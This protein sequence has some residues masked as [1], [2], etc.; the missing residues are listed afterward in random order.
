MCHEIELNDKYLWIGSIT[1]DELKIC[2]KC[3]KREGGKQWPK[4]SQRLKKLKQKQQFFKILFKEDRRNKRKD[5]KRR[6]K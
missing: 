5:I 3:A 1:K 2:M 6:I 4:E